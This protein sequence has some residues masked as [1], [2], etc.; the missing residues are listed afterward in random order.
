MRGLYRFSCV[1]RITNNQLSS[2]L[3]LIPLS[4][5]C[6]RSVDVYLCLNYT[7]Y[8]HNRRAKREPSTEREKTAFLRSTQLLTNVTNSFFVM[9]YRFWKHGATSYEN[10]FPSGV[11]LLKYSRKKEFLFNVVFFL[12]N[13]LCIVKKRAIRVKVLVSKGFY[14][15]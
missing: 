12:N 7:H 8:E 14:G 5:M 4:E 2:I 13:S 11:E 15:N 10:S 1:Y 6:S 9:C 3:R